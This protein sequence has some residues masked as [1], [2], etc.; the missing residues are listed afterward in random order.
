[1]RRLKR[2]PQHNFVAPKIETLTPEQIAQ[3]DVY[4]RRWISSGLST[5]K[6]DRKRA[7]AAILRLYRD[8][9]YEPPG[10]IIWCGCPLTAETTS[11]I[12]W[13]LTFLADMKDTAVF[14]EIPA[15]YRHHLSGRP[16]RAW[17]R[18]GPEPQRLLDDLGSRVFER[19]DVVGRAIERAWGNYR[20][21]TFP[22]DVWD[23]IGP[24]VEECVEESLAGGDLPLSF[25]RRPDGRCPENLSR[26]SCFDYRGLQDPAI[27]MFAYLRE[28]CGMREE[29]KKAVAHIELAKS[30]GWISPSTRICYACERPSLVRL[31][32]EGR[33]HADDGPA[34]AFPSGWK[35]YSEHGV[36]RPA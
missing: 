36:H 3:L 15:L 4:A 21:C 25:H 8:S 18:L 2:Q 13:R 5:R 10:K 16:R 29:T 35:I 23:A 17:N 33:L 28:V 14:G 34:L 12:I 7:E 27:V 24:G 20:D 9:G 26:W 19:V 6:V 31:D 22:Q 1:M 11:N 32:A 30:V